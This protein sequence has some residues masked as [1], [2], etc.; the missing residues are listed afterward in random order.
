MGVLQH[1]PTSMLVHNVP[2]AWMVGHKWGEAET[3]NVDEMNQYKSSL[4]WYLYIALAF[5]QVIK[6][7]I[8][9]A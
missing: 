2:F 8:I 7:P 5:K 9:K 1:R 4:L 6:V 3:R